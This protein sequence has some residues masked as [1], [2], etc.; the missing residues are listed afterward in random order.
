M[1]LEQSLLYRAYYDTYQQ[2]RFLHEQHGNQQALEVLRQ[3][4]AIG[5]T[6]AMQQATA[7]VNA[8]WLS[9]YRTKVFALGKQLFYSIGVRTHNGGGFYLPA[10]RKRLC[11]AV[12]K[13]VFVC[14]C[15][16]FLFCFVFVCLF[17]CLFVDF[18]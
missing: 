7:F 18:V 8:S 17:V 14:L 4:A 6:A 10:S 5:S 1:C 2:E 11:G 15:V 3:A 13:L 9:P 16:C 12:A